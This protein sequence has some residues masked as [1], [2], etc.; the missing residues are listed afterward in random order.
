MT[1]IISQ[2]NLFYVYIL[3]GNRLWIFTPDSRRFQDISALTYVAQLEIQT[4][5]E[6]RDIYLPRDGTLYITTNL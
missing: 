5:E 4:D 6:I 2:Q 1:K 3:S